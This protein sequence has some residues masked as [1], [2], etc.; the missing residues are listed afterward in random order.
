M[1]YKIFCKLC[2]SPTVIKRSSI[3]F[4]CMCDEEV[5]MIPFNCINEE[6]KHGGVYLYKIEGNNLHD[7]M[8]KEYT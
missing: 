3:F 1:N 8:E 2:H 4:T 7:E 5:R 6:F